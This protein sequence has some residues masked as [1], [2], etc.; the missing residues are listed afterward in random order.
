MVMVRKDW[1]PSHVS[2]PPRE[3]NGGK[4]REPAYLCVIIRAAGG[5]QP[6]A[7]TTCAKP[8]QNCAAQNLLSPMI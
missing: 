5:D 7:Q 6:P 2:L 1:P 3:L 8:M 4:A